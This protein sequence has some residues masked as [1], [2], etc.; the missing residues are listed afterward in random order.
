MNKDQSLRQ[1]AGKPRFDLISAVAVE[2]LAKVLADGAAKYAEH[3]W[4]Q[5]MDWSRT[6]RSAISHLMAIQRG[7]D[8][9]RESKLPHAAHLMANAMILDEYLRCKRGTDDRFKTLEAPSLNPPLAPV[10]VMAR[11]PLPSAP[12]Q[13]VALRP[14]KKMHRK[15]YQTLSYASPA[16]KRGPNRDGDGNAIPILKD[17]EVLLSL[18]EGRTALELAHEKKVS[19]ACA[20]DTIKR[21]KAKGF[22]FKETYVRR[23]QGVPGR[24]SY[25]YTW[26]G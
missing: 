5:G 21:L 20:R 2:D 18:V 15:T 8:F 11:R 7:E 6:I 23:P 24:G 19:Y 3:G 4:R 13:D 14:R 16:G 22:K 9:D 25:R 12:T 10:V 1:D 26:E 17:D